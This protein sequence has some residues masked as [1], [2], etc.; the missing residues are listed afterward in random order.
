M[1]EQR[2]SDAAF[3][4]A[5]KLDQWLTPGW[6]VLSWCRVVLYSAFAGGF[7]SSIFGS[8]NPVRAA[9]QNLTWLV[10]FWPFVLAHTLSVHVRSADASGIQL[11]ITQRQRDVLNFMVSTRARVLGVVVWLVMLPFGHQLL[12]LIPN[13]WFCQMTPF[14]YLGF[15]LCCCDFLYHRVIAGRKPRA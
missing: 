9:L 8:E 5:P 3:A 11:G 10:L 15:A 6:L 4:D 14:I 13:S 12:S 1:E 2:Q 7:L